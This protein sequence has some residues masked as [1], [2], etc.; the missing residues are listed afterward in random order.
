[1]ESI[2]S[3]LALYGSKN[4]GARTDTVFSP[5]LRSAMVRFPQKAGALVYP[6]PWVAVVQ[7]ACILIDKKCI[8]FLKQQKGHPIF[9]LLILFL[10]NLFKVW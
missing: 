7:T 6:L 5:Y 3:D 2:Y 10:N 9:L 4:E 1:M 8:L